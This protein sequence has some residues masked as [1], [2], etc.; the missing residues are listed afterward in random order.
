[1]AVAVVA[2]FILSFVTTSF[3]I[4][5]GGIKISHPMCVALARTGRTPI[6]P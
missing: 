5:L 4:A 2:G 1:M 3:L 6:W